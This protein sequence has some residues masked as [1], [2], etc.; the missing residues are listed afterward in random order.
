MRLDRPAK[1]E[2]T[3]WPTLLLFSTGMSLFLTAF[4]IAWNH[5]PE[6]W[7]LVMLLSFLGQYFL[8]TPMHE[9]VHGAVSNNI[10]INGIIGRLSAIPLLAPFLG[11]RF[12][13]LEHH[14]FTNRVAK[15]PD[16]WSGASF[17]PLRWLTQ[18]IYYYFIFLKDARRHNLQTYLNLLWQAGVCAAAIYFC[19]HLGKV[20]AMIVAW[21]IPNRLA[22]AWLSFSFNFLPH[23]PHEP[24][25]E[26]AYTKT[27]VRNHWLLTPIMF[28]Q[29][30]HNIHHLY[31][32]IRFYE[33]A[34]VWRAQETRL[35]AQGT[36]VKERVFE[37]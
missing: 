3:A 34:K 33:Y 6:Y 13:H 10:W 14:R 7:P 12:V 31:P 29:N 23:Y 27:L 5:F 18:D 36:V 19:A 22:V 4:A 20:P 26:T 11:F 28:F 16:L 37:L 32:N 2:G 9:S 8:F 25:Q 35:R 1:P 24:W 15:D 30:F 17:L 21:L